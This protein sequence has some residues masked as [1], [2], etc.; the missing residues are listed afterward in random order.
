MGYIAAQRDSRGVPSVCAWYPAHTP[1]SMPSIHLT[2]IALF[3]CL[4]LVMPLSRD[5]LT[6]LSMT[7]TWLSGA[8][9][10][11]NALVAP[12]LG[13]WVASSPLAKADGGA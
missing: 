7:L 9:S 5:T 10:L 11:R 6:E 12:L 8:K 2:H 1:L 4:A 13:E 3:P